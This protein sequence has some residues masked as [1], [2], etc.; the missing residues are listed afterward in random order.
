[1]N[2][3]RLPI[4]ELIMPKPRP[5]LTPSLVPAFR[6]KYQ[7]MVESYIFTD[8]IRGYFEKVFDDVAR[9]FGQGFWVQAEYGAGKTHFLVTL[10]ALLSY[11]DDESLW[12]SV[13]DES[14]KAMHRRL[15]TSRL[16]PVVLSLRGE[17]ASDSTLERS[18]LDIVLEAFQLSIEEEGLDGKIQLTAA[19]DIINWLESETTEIIRKDAGEFVKRKTGKPLEAYR[20]EY[21]VTELAKVLSEYLAAAKITPRNIAIGV[22]DRLAYIFRQLTESDLGYNGLLVVIDE[23][24]GWEKSHNSPEEKSRDAELLETLGFV[25][26]RDLGLPVY[27]IVASQS[28]V[29]AKLQGSGGGDR[30]IPLALLAQSNV[31]DYDVI[32]SR[33]SRELIPTRSP[34]IYDH[35]HYYSSQFQFAKNL[36]ESEFRDVFPFQPRCFEIVRR[37][38]ARE[39]PTARSGLT[40]FWEAVND[41]ELTKR[42]ELIRPADMVRSPHLIEQCLTKSVYKDLY[43]AYKAAESSIM[44]L[45]LDDEQIPLARD[46]LTTLFLWQAAYLEQPKSLTVEELAE[47]T[48]TTE[49]SDGINATDLVM[50]A[51][52][53]MKQLPQIE[54]DNTA[55]VFKVAEDA[56]GLPLRTFNEYRR[57]ALR[58]TLDLQSA[59]TDSLFFTARDTGG[60]VGLFADFQI[61]T[62]TSKRLTSRNLEYIGEVTVASSWRMDLGN[63][64]PKEDNHFRIIILTPFAS[65]NVQ[66]GTFEDQRIAVVVP[67]ELTEEVREATAAYKA[68]KILNDE[69]SNQTGKQAEEFRSWI[70]TQKQR[71]F[72]ELVSTHLKLYQ[73]GQILTKENLG[74]AAREAFG[75]GGSNDT[76]LGYIVDR[77]L[78]NSYRSLPVSTD[79]FRSGTVLTAPDY[80]KIFEGYF[81]AKDPKPAETSATKNFGVH[82]GLSHADKPQ[83]FSPQNPEAFRLIDELLASKGNQLRVWEI[84]DSLAR[85]PYGLPYALIQL[86]LL[87]Y[88]RHHFP[89]FDL[90]LKPNHRLQMRNGQAITRDRLT[91]ST[92]VDLAW[93]LRLEE[94]FDMLLPGSGPSWQDTLP[95]AQLIDDSLHAATD[96]AEIERQ[97]AS[98]LRSLASLKGELTSL[99]ST[100]ESLAGSLGERLPTAIRGTLENLDESTAGDFESYADFYEIAERIFGNQP[101]NLRR[102]MQTLGRL[103][104]LG[105]WTAEILSAYN[106]LNQAQPRERNLQTFRY[107]TL[108]QIKLETLVEGP[109]IWTRLKAD[110]AQFKSNYRNDYQKFHRDYYKELAL[111]KDQLSGAPAQLQ[112]LSLLNQ[113]DYL[114]K[115]LGDDLK[116]R[117]ETIVSQFK[118]CPVTDVT[119]VTVEFSPV[120]EKCGL[121]MNATPPSMDVTRLMEDL[122]SAVTAKIHQLAGAFAGREV[123]ERHEAVRPL[124]E[125]AQAEDLAKL[126]ATLRPDIIRAGN[127]LLKEMGIYTIELDLQAEL[128]KNYQ[129]L[130]ENRLPAL[131]IEIEKLLKD[132]FANARKD[133]PDKK[134][135]RIML[136]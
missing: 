49:S 54:F 23:Y 115:S 92:V 60:G 68:W 125:A 126:V 41:T 7:Q 56:G 95:Y 2:N 105:G 77:L 73:S 110:V 106:Y 72:G 17:G 122:N 100:L 136:K 30:F 22:K 128:K 116:P 25:L 99:K 31:R 98:L 33:R 3:N 13:Q 65:V 12:N 58:N 108:S 61:D 26:P 120:C 40:V 75:Q 102:A 78:S 85:P 87:A 21:G 76:R 29:P 34:E 67:G 113:I 66:P 109:E 107:N 96:Q 44:E 1:M 70:G 69:Y 124:L 32:I 42:A 130:E 50:L 6:R 14:L 53:S 59:L 82:L 16:F 117:F 121:P 86:Y 11:T 5:E 91:S 118:E 51:L 133:N 71:V 111:L 88:V 131:V 83:H 39:L 80:G 46:I 94:K 93:K 132:A 74:I 127:N 10:A 84:Y 19:Q 89:R 119:A 9:G 114:G 43:T 20:D 45:G 4:R 64:L 57:Q 63:S 35:F 112:V 101:E 52:D 81:N 24:E 38:T 129:S 47:A 134:T 62:P 104:T 123:A 79:S 37:V 15:S 55:A 48:L 135:F 97:T 28:S 27:T 36:P 8:T 18:L 103:R 90:M